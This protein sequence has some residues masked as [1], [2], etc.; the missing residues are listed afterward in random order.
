MTVEWDAETTEDRPNELI[1]WRSLEGADVY[2]EG[3]VRFEPA[4]GGRGTEV[5]VE[6]RYEPPGGRI[7]SKLAMLFRREPGQQVQDDLRAFKQVIETGDVVLSDATLFD[8]PHAAQPPEQLPDEIRGRAFEPAP[9]RSAGAA[10]A[11]AARGTSSESWSG[12]VSAEKA[13]ATE[14]TS[15]RASR[16]AG[17]DELRP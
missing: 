1:A 12:P 8:R 7:G 4:P 16:R 15:S 6:L 3:T 5:H 17:G 14:G 11:E 13:G 9:G 2:N 10:S